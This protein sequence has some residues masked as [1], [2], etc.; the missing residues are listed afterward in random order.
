MAGKNNPWGGGGSGDE[1]SGD[2]P[3]GDGDAG[4]GGGPRNP[5]LPGGGEPG[6]RRSASIEDI[7]KS[8]GP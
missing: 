5:W 6:K 2:G 3:A 7:F 8:R 4:S 1:P